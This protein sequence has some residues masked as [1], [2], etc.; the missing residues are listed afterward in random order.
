LKVESGLTADDLCIGLSEGQAVEARKPRKVSLQGTATSW[1][2]TGSLL[3]VT[4]GRSDIDGW[5]NVPGALCVWN[6]FGKAFN[7]D[8]PDH[9]FDHPS[10][11]MSVACHPVFPSIVAAGSFNGEIVVW[12]LSALDTLLAV[13]PIIE[14]S[15]K[16]SLTGR[17]MHAVS[18]VLL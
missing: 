4:Y 3:A 9:V 15:H 12:D 10:C 16:V 1:N 8:N 7:A 17:Y 18:L 13:S 14:H 2:S 6:V 11:L 5:C